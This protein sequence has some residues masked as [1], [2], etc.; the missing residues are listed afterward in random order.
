[1]DGDDVHFGVLSTRAW[2]FRSASP[3]EM[4]STAALPVITEATT[5]IIGPKWGIRT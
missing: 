5:G 4:S 3:R 2:R 1:V